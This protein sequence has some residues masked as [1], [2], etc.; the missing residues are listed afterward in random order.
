MGSIRIPW[1]PPRVSRGSTLVAVIVGLALV[2]CAGPAGTPGAP[3]TGSAPATNGATATADASATGSASA[4]DADFVLNGWSVPDFV[5]IPPIEELAKDP[6][7]YGDVT[8]VNFNDLAITAEDVEA[9]RGMGLKAAFLNW[10]GVP[11]N[12]AFTH[13]I[14]R[15][16]DEL[17]INLVATTNFEFDAVKA[18]ADVQNV[19][20]LD[21][22][23]I[24][25]GVLDPTVWPG[26]LQPARERD[27]T[28]TMWSQGV[29]GWEVGHDQDICT[30]S[31]YDP[32]Y[33][34]ATVADGIGKHYPDGAKVGMIHWS[35]NHPV[36]IGRDQGFRDRLAELGD[37]YEMITDMPMDDPNR[38]Q[39]VAAALITRFPDVEVIY[40]PWDS[41]PAEG[42]V[43]AIRAA[44]R[45]N[46]IKVAT[47]DLGFVGAHEIAH[48]GIIFHD[49]AQAV[50]EGG[51]TMAIASALCRAGKEVPPFILVPTYGVDRD[52]LNTGWLYMHGPDI[53][54]PPE[55]QLPGT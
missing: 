23:I 6:G 15:A 16:F 4:G 30:I 7:Y 49:T 21:P 43:A 42:I 24:I 5:Q 1:E 45:E 40:G 54:L 8:P 55:D 32:A 50:Y 22:D 27:I 25:T 18:S 37:Q 26:I 44:G 46:D 14:E 19:L 34:G 33:D 38:A 13:G 28:I 12:Q 41:P 53:P 3:A 11:Y 2:A 36:V 17:G 47:M 20:P 9:I 39:E 31:S 48:D 35:F 29:E 10:S 51:R 52:N